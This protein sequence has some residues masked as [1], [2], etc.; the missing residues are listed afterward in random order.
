MF[1]YRIEDENGKGLY[2]N[3]LK[4]EADNLKRPHGTI[5][6]SLCSCCWGHNPPDI[7]FPDHFDIMQKR[8]NKAFHFGF[9]NIHQLYRWFDTVEAISFIKKTGFKI[10][11]YKIDRR[12]V[13]V[14]DKQII[15]KK[16]H[17]EFVEYVD[18]EINHLP[19]KSNYSN[20][21]SDEVDLVYKLAL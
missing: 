3:K 19:R 10:A 14:S 15:F 1:F 2:R 18:F 17:E 11:K 16:G 21:E 6:A 5:A 8:T 9:K 4:M 20:L 7:D 13:E 12:H